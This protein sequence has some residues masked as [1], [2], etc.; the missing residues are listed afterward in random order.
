MKKQH[1][2]TLRFEPELYRRVKMA[3]QRRGGSVTAFVQEAVARKLAEEDAALLVEAFTLV[4][5]DAHQANIEF[6]QDAQREVV[7]KVE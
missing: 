5:E 2:L 6:A 1:A 7:L 3:C 4:G